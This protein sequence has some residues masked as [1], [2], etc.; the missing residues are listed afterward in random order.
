MRVRRAAYVVPALLIGSVLAG[1]T[2]STQNNAGS[3]TEPTS[4]AP[5][6]APAKTTAATPSATPSPSATSSASAST[7]PAAPACTTAQLR[8]SQGSV[9]GAAGTTYVTYYL[10]NAGSTTCLLSGYPGVA[11]LRADGSV[12]QHPAGRS[13]AAHGP[14]QVA[15]GS[16]AKFVLRTGDPGA[17]PSCSYGW[18]TAT[19]QV[20]PPGQTAAIRQ[21]SDVQAC[22]LV[23]DPISAS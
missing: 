15:S 8:L 23:V 2:G 12:I 16:K 14:V 9:Q 6:H 21:P 10:K 4:S 18:K 5:A 7:K 13:G 17:N 11:L 20:Y 1:C 22:N 19:V 3:P